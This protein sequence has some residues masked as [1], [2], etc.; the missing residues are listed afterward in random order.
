MQGGR[1]HVILDAI[2]GEDTPAIGS[3]V[4]SSRE[5]D[6]DKIRKTK[7]K[8]PLR[9]ACE[10]RNLSVDSASTCREMISL[11]EDW[12]SR[13]AFDGYGNASQD[14]DDDVQVTK[15]AKTSFDIGQQVVYRGVISSVITKQGSL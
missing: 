6:L 12:Q 11:L 3:Q 5:G 8:E 2:C 14:D 15:R 4:Q 1:R 7:R 10:E 13:K 9:K